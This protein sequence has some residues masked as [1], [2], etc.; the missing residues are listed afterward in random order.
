MK[1][2]S[3]G[4]AAPPRVS[5]ETVSPVRPDNETPKTGVA[6]AT[7]ARGND[8]LPQSFKV[9]DAAKDVDTTAVQVHYDAMTKTIVSSVVNKE[10]GLVVTEMPPEALRTL[11]E[12]TAEF[13]GKIFNIKA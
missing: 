1:I 12:R 7:T 9:P 4:T 11:A 6:P 13:R 3:P 2:T 8:A 5:T 10:T